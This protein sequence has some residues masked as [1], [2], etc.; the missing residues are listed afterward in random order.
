[1]AKPN[2][3]LKA[4]MASDKKAGIPENSPKDKALD[5]K[6]MSKAKKKKK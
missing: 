5:K 1:M 4:D 6:L 2:P 3:F